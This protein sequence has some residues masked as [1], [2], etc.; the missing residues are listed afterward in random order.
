MGEA[1]ISRDKARREESLDPPRRSRS[2]RTSASRASSSAASRAASPSTSAAPSAFLPG[3]QVDIRPIRDVGPLMN[4][5]QPFAD[6]ED[7]PPPRQHRRVP[8]RHPGGSPRRAAHRAGPA[9]ARKARCVEGV[10][11]NITDYGAFVDLGGIDGLLHVTDIELEARQ[12]P[13]P[14]AGGRRHGQG[15]DR[16]DQ[17]RHPAHQPRHEA[18]AVRP[19]GRRRGQVPGGR[20]VHRPGHQHHRLRRLRRAGAGHRGPGP[21]LRDELDQEE[22]PPGQDRLHLQEV[23]VDGARGRSGQAPHLARPQAGPGQSV[24]GLRREVSDRHDQSRARSR[25]SPNSACSSASTATSTAWSTSPTST[26]RRPGEEAIE[27]LQEGRH[28]QGRGA[29]R[30]RREGAHLARHQAARRRPDGGRPAA[31]SK[32]Q[33]GHLRGGARS[34]GGIEV[35]IAGTDVTA[36]IRRAIC[37]AT[38]PSSGPERFA[39]GEKVD[40]RVIQRSTRPPAEIRYRSRRWKS[41]R[42]RKPW[43]NMAP[44]TPAPRWATSWALP[45]PR[46][47]PRATPP[48]ANDPPRRQTGE[49]T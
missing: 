6:P 9:A 33:T 5:P 41:P 2:T 47:R 31:S 17:P 44:P 27:R 43:R 20:Q 15:P 48:D 12:P 28:G 38:A 4:L 14:S 8:P 46:P 11:K 23:E 32:G 37:R 36:F 21:R 10:V 24:G 3:S 49:K 39:V 34:G 7:G 26:G 16:Q 19:V 45:C 29:R 1:V 13:E 40:A 30:R 25:T 35:K 42:R 22:R 18:A